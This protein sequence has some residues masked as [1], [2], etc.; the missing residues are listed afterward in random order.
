LLLVGLFLLAF[1]ATVRQASKNEDH[2]Y[3]G[4]FDLTRNLKY[5]EVRQGES[6]NIFDGVR[7][8]SM[9][10]VVIGH[11]YNFL[12]FTGGAEN[13]P[14]FDV[15]TKKPFFLVLI[16]GLISVDIFFALG[17][18]FLAFVMLR[19]KKIDAKILIL[20]VVNRALRIWPSYILT[21]LFYFSILM[22]MG[23][24]IYWYRL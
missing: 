14:N 3:L 1:V 22:M 6:L 8:I 23:S 2:K 18:F 21:M 16:M 7:A 5:L 11:C 24:G 13:L 20:G 12:L 9:M 10:W 4:C 17:G 15:P 19:Q